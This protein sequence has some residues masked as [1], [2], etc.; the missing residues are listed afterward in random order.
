MVFCFLILFLAKSSDLDSSIDFSLLESV[1][2]SRIHFSTPIIDL[3]TTKE[4]S[5]ESFFDICQTQSPLFFYRYIVFAKLCKCGW[6]PLIYSIL[7]FRIVTSGADVGCD[8]CLYPTDVDTS[9]SLC[10]VTL[11]YPDDIG[12]YLRSFTI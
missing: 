4:L 6:Y 11:E 7:I 9:H 8:Y 3:C 10:L 1:L 2:Y 5:A 12:F